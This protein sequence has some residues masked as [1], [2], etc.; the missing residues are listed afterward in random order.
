MNQEN[1]A[2]RENESAQIRDFVLKPGFQMDYRHALYA[3]YKLKELPKEAHKKRTAILTQYAQ[4]NSF[5]S[6]FSL[7]YEFYR[8]V[9]KSEMERRKKWYWNQIRKIGYLILL[10]LFHP[11][12]AVPSEA[13]RKPKQAPRNS[14]SELSEWLPIQNFSRIRSDYPELFFRRT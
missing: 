5:L 6:I 3:I 1:E 11:E 2:E 14:A 13:E 7:F 10:D 4:E 9:R 8:F 12:N